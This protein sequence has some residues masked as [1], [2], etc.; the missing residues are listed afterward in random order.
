MPEV[1]RRGYLY[2]AQPPLYKVKRGKKELFLK[3][4]QALATFVLDAGTEGLAI[5]TRDN[6]VTLT[7]QPLR[8]L[9]DE[10][11]RFR[12][13][14]ER[15]RRFADPDVVKAVVRETS[16]DVD[17]LHDQ[18]RVQ[19]AVQQLEAALKRARPEVTYTIEIKDDP[20]HGCK[21]IDVFS[22]AGVASRTSSVGHALLS[23]VDWRRLR[24][25]QAT[26]DAI[27]APPY[28]TVSPGNGESGTEISNVDAL[29]DYVDARGH[30]GWELQRYKGLGEMNADTLWETTMNPETRVLLQVRIDDGMEAEE[31]FSIL[32][33]DQVEPR[34]EFIEKNAMDVRNLDI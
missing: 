29:W 18:A 22:R 5:R 13:L 28:T 6:G 14:T 8:N 21:K 15:L 2:I 27:G 9:F 23:T 33:G 17:A 26:I 1:I 30:K 10:L 20:E 12:E 19:Q 31:L 24:E 25:L 7:G 34:R 32:M 16:L 3:D 4:D 11:L